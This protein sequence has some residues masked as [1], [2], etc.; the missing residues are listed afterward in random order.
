MSSSENRTSKSCHVIEHER[1]RKKNERK[2]QPR[3]KSVAEFFD[4]ADE[5][6]LGCAL[7]FLPEVRVGPEVEGVG[8]AHVLVAD[9]PG[10]LAV[11]PLDVDAERLEVVSGQKVVVPVPVLLVLLNAVHRCY[12]R[13][14]RDCEDEHCSGLY[15]GFLLVSLQESAFVHFPIASKI[16]FFITLNGMFLE[17]QS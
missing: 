17:I 15:K 11:L 16:N 13:L 3:L 9:G 5:G 14:H 4:F 6:M 2:L 8:G 10:S 12:P 7:F 1:I